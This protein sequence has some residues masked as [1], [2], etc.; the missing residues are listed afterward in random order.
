[1]RTEQTKDSNFGASRE[2]VANLQ[3]VF[4]LE[5]TSAL[6]REQLCWRLVVGKAEKQA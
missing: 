6:D 4:S 1:M 2:E 5:V 3:R